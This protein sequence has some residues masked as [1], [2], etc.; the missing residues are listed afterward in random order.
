MANENFMRNVINCE[1][2]QAQRDLN[3]QYKRIKDDYEKLTTF[4]E[5]LEKADEEGR[6]P[7]LD[8]YAINVWKDGFAS[9]NS[10]KMASE[11]STYLTLL[12]ARYIVDKNN[13]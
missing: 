9:H 10:T 11:I 4:V 6:E 5:E 3:Y 13:Q 7:Q 8:S 2:E 12:K 1:I